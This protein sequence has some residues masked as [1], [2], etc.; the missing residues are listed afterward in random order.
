MQNFTIL[1][2]VRLAIKNLFV[3]ILVAVVVGAAT[4]SYCN[5]VI[6]PLYT[7]TSNVLVSNGALS[8]SEQLEEITQQ[9]GNSVD[10]Q[11]IVTSRNLVKITINFLKKETD[12]YKQLA[13]ELNIKSYKSLKAGFEFPES[14]DV[15]IHMDVSYTS[16]NPDKAIA[17]LNKFLELLPAYTKDKLDD[18]VVLK[19][20]MA[21]SAPKT[22]PSTF[23]TTATATLISVVATYLIIL[24]IY[25]A[26]TIIQSDDDFKER[27][28][29]PVLGCIPDFAQAKSQDSYY[30][31]SKRGKKNEKPN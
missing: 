27:F 4:F 15:T 3:L 21:D 24:L 25:S 22:Y 11:D 23:S 13:D 6:D 7:A 26:N 16:D 10:N 14:E 17:I 28:D 1:S 9:N 30:Y 8:A 29:V 18:K 5:F 12:I 31:Y 2:L 19:P 20:N